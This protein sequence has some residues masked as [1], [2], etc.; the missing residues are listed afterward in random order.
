MKYVTKAFTREA[1]ALGAAIS[2]TVAGISTMAGA[3]ATTQGI[4]SGITAAWVGWYVR[5]VSTP[6][7][8]ANERIEAAAESAR[9]AALADVSSLAVA[10]RP[11]EARKAVAKARKTPAKKPRR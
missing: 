11:G 2:I 1:A 3:S 7:A 4:I 9:N 8:A 10:E 6:R 5:S